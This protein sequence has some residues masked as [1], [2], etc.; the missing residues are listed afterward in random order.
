MCSVALAGTLARARCIA[1]TAAG[2]RPG[3]GTCDGA[4]PPSPVHKYRRGAGPVLAAAV[5]ASIGMT[6]LFGNNKVV[7]RAV[8]G[9]WNE[10]EEDV[11]GNILNVEVNFAAVNQHVQ[12]FAS[13]ARFEL[14]ET[15]AERLAAELLAHFGAP[16]LRLRVTKPGANPAARAVGVEIERSQ[17]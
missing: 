9:E 10:T 16:W 7:H 5:F 15:F 11:S 8:K 4:L 6:I 2:S 17:P 14:V 3:G 13:A 1:A 12:A